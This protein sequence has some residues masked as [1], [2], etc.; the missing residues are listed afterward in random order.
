MITTERSIDI[1]SPADRFGAVLGRFMHIYDFHP[2]VSKVD[3]L[4]DATAG[5]PK[6]DAS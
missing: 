2:R 3:L 4:R 1:E 6:T 5:V